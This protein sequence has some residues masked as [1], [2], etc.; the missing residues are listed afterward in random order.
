MR[1]K[2]DNLSNKALNVNIYLCKYTVFTRRLRRCFRRQGAA[3]ALAVRR[4]LV[5]R[6]TPLLYIGER[7]RER[8]MSGDPPSTLC[9]NAP[10][11]LRHHLGTTQSDADVRTNVPFAD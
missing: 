5:Q 10:Y 8:A 3:A 11:F 2:Y 9:A 4:H 1:Q 6:D 7:T